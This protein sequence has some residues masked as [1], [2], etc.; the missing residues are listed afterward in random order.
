MERENTLK[1]KSRVINIYVLYIWHN[2]SISYFLM[3][4]YIMR[5]KITSLYEAYL[6]ELKLF[7]PIIQIETIH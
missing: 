5:A 1:H 7:P 3:R 4:V 6:D 2:F